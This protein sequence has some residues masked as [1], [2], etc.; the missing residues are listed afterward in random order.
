MVGERREPC[1]RLRRELV[2][3]RVEEVCVGEPIAAADAATNLVELASPSWSARSTIRVFACGMSSPDSMIVVETSTSA[4]PARNF[5]I[6]SSSS[7]SG[8][9]PCA[10]RRRRFGQHLRGASRPPPRSSRPGCAGRSLPAARDLALE[11]RSISS[12]SYSP[13]NVRI[14]R[15]PSGG[16]SITEMSRRPASDMCSVRGIGVALSASTST[17]SRSW[18]SSSFCAT[19][20]RCSS[21]TTTRPSSFGITSRESTLWVPISTSTFPS[22]SRPAPASTSAG[23][24]KRETISTRTGKSRYRSGTCSSAAARAPSSARA[25]A[26]ACR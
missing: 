23:L 25:S 24:R 19:P 22:A 1:A 21:S 9:W 7:R 3:L 11:R 2:R 14:G 5:I 12:S 26:P 18:R 8:I 10:T 17:S 16:V 6:L 15:R 13:T 20:K 4:S